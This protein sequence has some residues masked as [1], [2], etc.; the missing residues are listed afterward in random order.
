MVLPLALLAHIADG[1]SGLGITDTVALLAKLPEYWAT[2]P[3]V[4]HYIMN[5]EDAQRKSSRANLLITD[6]WLAVFA[7]N[8][9]L[10]ANSY[11]T[12]RPA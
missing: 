9:L 4:P 1:V 5:M 8:S 2:D 10:C 12:D 7:T 11:P 6:D 3:R